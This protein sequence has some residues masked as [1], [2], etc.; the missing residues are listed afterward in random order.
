MQMDDIAVSKDD[1]RIIDKQVESGRYDN[2]SDVVSAGLRLLE[3][4][5]SETEAWMRREI[6]RRTAE[7]DRDPSIGIPLEQAVTRLDELHRKTLGLKR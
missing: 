1:K 3:E 2:A 6:P 4:V 5:Q 7:Y